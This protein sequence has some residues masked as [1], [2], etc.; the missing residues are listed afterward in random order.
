MNDIAIRV[1]NLS[2]QYRIG[3]PE[4]PYKTIREALTNAVTGP[5]RRLRG[6]SKSEIRNRST[7]R[8]RQSPQSD[9]FIW[10]LKDVSFEV[11]RGE[12][13]SRAEGRGGGH[14]FDSPST[15]LRTSI[16]RNGGAN[17]KFEIRNSKS[18]LPPRTDRA[19]E[20]LPER[21]HPFDMPVVLWPRDKGLRTSLGMKKAETRPKPAEG[22]TA[23]SARLVLSLLKGRGFFRRGEVHRHAGGAPLQRH[24]RAA[25]LLRRRPSGAGDFAD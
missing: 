21:R 23:S 8:S 25:G 17:C 4:A 13:A 20:D 24:G 19:R 3:G 6:D 9:G 16:G 7:E 15:E 10:A 12:A 14:A 5:F 11:K 22:L 1:E 18:L 2:K